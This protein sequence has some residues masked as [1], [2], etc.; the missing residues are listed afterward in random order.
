[1]VSGIAKANVAEGNEILSGTPAGVF[2]FSGGNDAQGDGTASALSV[3]IVLPMFNEEDG[4]CA[5]VDEIALALKSIR[6]EVIVVDDCSTDETLARLSDHKSIVPALRILHHEKNAGQSRAIRTGVLAARAPVVATLDGDGQN[7][8]ADLLG[9]INHLDE[10]GVTV[11]A[12]ERQKRKDSAAKKWASQAA[13][14]IRKFL[15]RDGA[16]DT[17]CGLKVFKREAYLRLP[18]FDHQHRYLPA[19]FAREGYR[20]DFLPVSH[21]ARLHGSSKY[22][23]LGRLA[24]A[25]RDIIGVMWLNSRFKSPISISEVQNRSEYGIKGGSQLSANPSEERQG[26]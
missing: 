2:G 22:T 9:L 12:G 14:K 15:L 16:I 26:E 21:R 7:N 4:A 20:I 10:K 13:N 17:G 6:F 18:Y 5:L 19:L 25:F 8:P 3:S 23:N 24:V 1:M 11:V